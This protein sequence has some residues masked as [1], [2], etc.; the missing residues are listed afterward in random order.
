MPVSYKRKNSMKKSKSSKGSK[1]SKLSKRVKTR[2]S[3]KTKKRLRRKS[4]NGSVVRKMRGGGV[5]YPDKYD[6]TINTNIGDKDKT[7]FY[8]ALAKD[9][10][11]F[12]L[13]INPNYSQMYVSFTSSKKEITQ[14]QTL[15]KI[16]NYTSITLPYV[17]LL[18]DGSNKT[19]YG[20]AQSI[21]FEPIIGA[22]YII[23]KIEPNTL[24]LYNQSKR[25]IQQRLFDGEKIDL[26]TLPKGIQNDI[27]MIKEHT[28]NTN[29]KNKN[30]YR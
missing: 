24:T 8:I 7:L 3:T 17:V 19:I 22:S 14:H 28:N 10:N 16:S 12:R 27:T 23:V 21:H 25:N 11:N 13:P 2:K 9:N 5:N 1:S 6:E 26:S 30:Y 29:D 4:K 15:F 18:N 20:M